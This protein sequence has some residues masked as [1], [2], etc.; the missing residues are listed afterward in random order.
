V[1]CGTFQTLAFSGEHSVYGRDT[2][3]LTEP[4]FQYES[5]IS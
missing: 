1:R 3:T 2:A 5:A 4:S